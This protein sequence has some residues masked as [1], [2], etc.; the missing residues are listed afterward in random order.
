MKPPKKNKHQFGL[1]DTPYDPRDYQL[2]AILD[3]PPLEEIP[4]DFRVGELFVKDQKDSDFCSSYMSCLMSEIQEGVTLEPSWSFAKSKEI[5]GNVDSWGQDLRTALQAHKNFGALPSELSPHSIDT[6]SPSFLRDIKNWPKL[7]KKA[8][9]YRKKTF[10]KVTGPYDAF[11]NARAT[12]WKLKDAIGSGV[13]W[14]W[15]LNQS[16]LKTIPTSGGGHAV[17]YIGAT[18]M[19]D[20]TPV[21][22]LQNSYG[23]KAGDKGLFYMTR[24]V[25]NHFSNK[26]GAY[27]FV[28]IS[29][30]EAKECMQNGIKLG[31]SW[32]ARLLKRLLAYV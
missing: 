21:I 4:D 5:S 8:Y 11:D 13:L 31:D 6:D 15:P 18:F 26:Y 3:L 23:E 22:I 12:M 27:V 19:D 17:T 2:G 30:E 28:D 24:E 32:L 10:F 16:Y 1:L 7:E 14:G 20:G 9:P 25:Y 29:P